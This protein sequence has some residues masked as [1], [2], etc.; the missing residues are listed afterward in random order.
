MAETK[1][2]YGVY[3]AYTAT[4]VGIED[5]PYEYPP[6]AAR[7]AGYATKGEQLNAYANTRC[8]ASQTFEADSKEEAEAI[9]KDFQKKFCDKAWLE[10]NIYPY[11]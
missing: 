11:V 10:K 7:A 5:S 9:C 2:I 3:F 6:E 1:K 4:E 8:P